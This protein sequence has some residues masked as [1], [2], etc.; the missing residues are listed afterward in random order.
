M[1]AWL[2]AASLALLVA[3]CAWAGAGVARLIMDDIKRRK[4]GR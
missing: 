1:A 3:F 2:F 4:G